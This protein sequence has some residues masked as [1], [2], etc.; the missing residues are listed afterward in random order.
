MK[1]IV[2]ASLLALTF[3]SACHTPS[4]EPKAISAPPPQANPSIGRQYGETLQGGIAKAKEIQKTT[5]DRIQQMDNAAN[6][7]QPG[8]GE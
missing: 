3:V 4:E 2:V 1:K 7:N 8:P 5:K 6:Q